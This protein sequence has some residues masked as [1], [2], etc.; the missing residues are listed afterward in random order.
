M[1]ENVKKVNK[2]T[3]IKQQFYSFILNAFKSHWFI[4]INIIFKIEKCLRKKLI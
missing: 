4:T 1:I 3:F 2:C